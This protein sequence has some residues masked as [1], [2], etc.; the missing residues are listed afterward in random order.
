MKRIHI[1]ELGT[2]NEAHALRAAA[3]CWGAEVTVSWVGNSAQVVDY[4]SSRPTHD[5]VIISGHGDASGLLLP[6]LHESVR[7]RFPF[8]QRITPDQFREF[9]KLDGT[10]VVSLA[11]ET[12]REPFANAFLACGAE[13]YIGP[14]D[15]PG[16]AAALMYA[17]E[18]LYAFIATGASVADAHEL[19]TNQSDDRGM[20]RIWGAEQGKS[21]GRRDRSRI[22]GH[23]AMTRKRTESDQ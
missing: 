2:G 8:D 15:S 22:G 10:P 7:H 9:V 23:H 5:L 17:L 18:F 13:W 11:C 3:E 19:A 20:F 12:G 1:L 21:A 14:T 6:K 4:L 16:G